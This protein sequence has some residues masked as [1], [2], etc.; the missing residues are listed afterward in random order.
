MKNVFLIGFMGCGK[1]SVA[2]HLSKTYGMDVLEMDQVITERVG[3]SIADIFTQYGETYFRDIETELVKEIQ[4]KDNQVVSCG[5][6]IVL[7]TQNVDT[8]RSAGTIVCLT[9]KPE[10]ILERV[11][12]DDAR[13]L[14]KG[15]K[16]LTFINEMM[17]K[18]RDKYECAADIIV[19]TDGKT[20][21]EICDEIVAYMKWQER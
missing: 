1:S 14:L 7:R 16:N 6:G 9:A 3:M 13:P 18:R 15:N 11:K 10:T 20:I 4:H 12:D 2:A 17:E 8:M 21:A 5:G 19:E